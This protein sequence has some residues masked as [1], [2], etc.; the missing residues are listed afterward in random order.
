MKGGMKAAT[1]CGKSMR[2]HPYTQKATPGGGLLRI[3]RT[4]RD[5]TVV[6]RSAMASNLRLNREVG[7]NDGTICQYIQLGP[8]TILTRETSE[9]SRQTTSALC[10][11]LPNRRRLS[12][13]KKPSKHGL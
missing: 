4:G 5:S 6:K 13:F 2:E 9:F 3:W 7:T 10:P 11:F 12:A 1:H 8:Q